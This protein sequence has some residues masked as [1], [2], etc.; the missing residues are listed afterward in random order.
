[1]SGESPIGL[2]EL[3]D[4]VKLELFSHGPGSGTVPFFSVDEVSLELKVTVKKD[5]KGGLKI[6]VVELDGGVSREDVHTIQVKLTPLVNKEERIRL[7]Q[8]YFPN[9]VEAVKR[10]SVWAGTK[11]GDKSQKEGFGG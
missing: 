4:Q 3:I 9:E 2:A 7:F 11:G 1:M 5:V 10:A 8:Q 6:Y